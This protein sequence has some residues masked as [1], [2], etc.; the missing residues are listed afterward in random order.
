MRKN[1]HPTH[2]HVQK[3][4]R[5][6]SI[7]MHVRKHPCGCAFCKLLL[8]AASQRDVNVRLAAG[9]WTRP[10]CH[11]WKTDS[12]AFWLGC[13]CVP[14]ERP[15]TNCG[16]TIMSTC[17]C[18]ERHPDRNSVTANVRGTPRG[19]GAGQ[20]QRVARQRQFRYTPNESI[21]YL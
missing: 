8:F 20:E 3:H 17:R 14:T 13:T 21:E 10:S 18:A 19:L 2:R 6:P 7:R 9:A 5:C 12:I 4:T 11:F 1:Q 16:S 15:T